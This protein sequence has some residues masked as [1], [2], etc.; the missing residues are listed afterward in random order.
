VQA[1]LLAV[2]PNNER[3][4][5]ALPKALS[6][7]RSSVTSTPAPPI[8]LPE[9][10]PLTVRMPELR[11]TIS[12]EPGDSSTELSRTENEPDDTNALLD[13]STNLLE[14]SEL[15]QETNDYDTDELDSDTTVL[16]HGVIVIGAGSRSARHR[17]STYRGAD[18]VHTDSQRHVDT[19]IP[20]LDVLVP[21]MSCSR[22]TSPTLGPPLCSR[23]SPDTL[24]LPTAPPV[25]LVRRGR[26]GQRQQLKLQF[27]AVHVSGVVCLVHLRSAV[28]CSLAA[29]TPWAFG[30]LKDASTPNVVTP[31]S[32]P[33]KELGYFSLVCL[34]RAHALYGNYYYTSL[35]P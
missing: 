29:A 9:L 30:E 31:P 10:E 20:P 25:P 11:L 8:V 2:P 19:S 3:L 13:S 16:R 18:A 5:P 22:P 35:Q 34:T 21:P 15:L 26:P 7:P 32:E 14:S 1:A 33:T 23:A 24:L 6:H 28:Q 17:N 27:G 4:P 12:S